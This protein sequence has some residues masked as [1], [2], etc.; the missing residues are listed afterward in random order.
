MGQNRMGLN[1]IGWWGMR[2]GGRMGQNDLGWDWAV[3]VPQQH[4]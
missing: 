3:W 1:G 4:S 2:E